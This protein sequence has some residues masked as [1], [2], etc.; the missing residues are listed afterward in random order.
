MYESVHFTSSL[1]DL[2]SNVMFDNL[3]NGTWSLSLHSPSSTPEARVLVQ[4]VY[5]KGDHRQ[6]H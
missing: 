5:L 4:I 1:P 3:L 2:F 6:Y